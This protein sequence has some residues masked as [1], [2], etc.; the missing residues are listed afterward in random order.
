MVSKS[1][2]VSRAAACN[3]YAKGVVS[4]KIVS[5]LFIRKVCQ[6]HLDDLK[7]SKRADFPYRWDAAAAGRVL[8]FLEDTIV[9][10]SGN[11]DGEVVR[12]QAIGWQ[13]FFA[14]A[15]FG[16]KRKDTGMRRYQEV[17]CQM[18]KGAGKSAFMA[19]VA[20][21]MLTADSEA[22]PL[23]NVLARDFDQAGIVF[24]NI[25]TTVEHH[26]GFQN[27]LEIYGGKMRNNAV[28]L[29]GDGGQKKGEIRRLTNSP[30]GR[31]KSGTTPH[32]NIY[33]EVSEYNDSITL[34][35]TRRNVKNRS[36]PLN[37]MITNAGAGVNS[38]AYPYYEKAKAV[39]FGEA[40][41]PNHFPLVYELDPDDSPMEDESVW[42]KT[43]PSLL[44]DPPL[45][46]WDYIRNEVKNAEAMPVL[47]NM[48]LRMHFNKWLEASADYFIDIEKVED[49][50]VDKLDDKKLAKLPLVIGLDLSENRDMTA[51][52]MLWR[53]GDKYFARSHFWLPED[54][55]VDRTRRLNLPFDKWV[56][57]GF[58]TATPGPV[59]D[60]EYIALWLKE[61]AAN[62]SVRAVSSDRYNTNY[63]RTHCES[64][65]LGYFQPDK[66]GVK[67]RPGNAMMFYEHPQGY[68]RSNPTKKKGW[69]V[70]ENGL[71]DPLW[72]P[73]S[74]KLIE[75]A[76]LRGKIQMED[77]PVMRWNFLGVK[78]SMDKQR[79]KLLDKLKS[80]SSID[81]VVALVNAVGLANALPTTPPPKKRLVTRVDI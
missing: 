16:W 64:V 35:I 18:A 22:Y 71:T 34:D 47:R 2:F 29:L 9:M 52:V 73:G 46:G 30:E 39:A 32:C 78:V 19:G 61:T 42:V 38:V 50:C 51:A 20:L 6:R 33:D 77:N 40:D 24:D 31:G 44:A 13:E 4:G 1:R 28:L 7:A 25:I 67:M 48:L 66:H 12:F 68:F 79:N 62:W 59:I 58:I 81:G 43:N 27:R 37:I 10:R 53:D 14:G 3:A 74:I 49:V 60:Y 41:V 23:V 56:E 21:Y 8:C 69:R 57:S 17:Y 80:S 15:V 26:N 11:D 75:N 63:F 76:I 5:G 55:L 36:Q 70:F 72:F 65:G 54:G 45:P